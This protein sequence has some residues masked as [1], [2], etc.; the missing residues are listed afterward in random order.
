MG[1]ISRLS[2]PQRTAMFVAVFFALWF[3]LAL[4]A[5]AV[6]HAMR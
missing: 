6:L 2:G 3:S 1:S 5:E 4:M